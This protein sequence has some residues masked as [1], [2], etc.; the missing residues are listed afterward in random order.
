M[1]NVPT[2]GGVVRPRFVGFGTIVKPKGTRL[3]LP[4][5][6]GLKSIGPFWGGFG[7][8]VGDGVLF[9]VEPTGMAGWLAAARDL[10]R[11]AAGLLPPSPPITPMA[12]R[13]A[14]TSPPPTITPMITMAIVVIPP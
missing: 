12:M 3:T 6:S 7:T 13:M 4:M 9:G 5:G 8:V 11:F 1:L 14:P 2:P 10:S